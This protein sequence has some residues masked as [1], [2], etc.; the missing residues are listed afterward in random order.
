MLVIFIVELVVFVEFFVALVVE[1]VVVVG[2]A[3]NSLLLFE[4]IV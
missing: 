3:C 4:L 2:I 1:L